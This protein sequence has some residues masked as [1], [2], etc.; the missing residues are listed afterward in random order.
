MAKNCGS[1]AKYFS[2]IDECIPLAKL[3]LPEFLQSITYSIPCT[4][5]SGIRTVDDLEGLRYCRA[6]ESGLNIM[7]SDLTA[8][9]SALYDISIVQG[10]K[11]GI[12]F[13]VMFMK[14]HFVGA[15]T[16]ANSS[17]SSMRSFAHLVS[18][19]TNGQRAAVNG[20][21]YEVVVSGLLMFIS[22][23]SRNYLLLHLQATMRF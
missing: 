1:G 18:I 7:V 16:V 9:Y 13:R 8:D 21:R 11:L 3:A 5:T 19:A 15:L 6:I 17:M 12:D 10:L 20:A 22:N 4:A 14:W 23:D 2:S